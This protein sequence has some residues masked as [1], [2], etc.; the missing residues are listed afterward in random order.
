MIEGTCDNRIHEVKNIFSHAL[1]SG[2]E[3]GAALAIEYNGETVVNL[4]GGFQDAD[5]TKKWKEDTLVNV[6]S[7]TKGITA[8]C[9]S[10]LIDQGKL[11]R[12]QKVSFYWR[13]RN[14]Y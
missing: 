14:I 13:S 11:V 2:F 12:N 10:Q 6:F 5:Q 3:T 8:I 7:V 1:N 9:V 4:W